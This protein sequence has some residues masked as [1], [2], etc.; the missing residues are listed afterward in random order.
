MLE[1]G[2]SPFRDYLYYLFLFTQ[3]YPS[4]LDQ[5]ATREYLLTSDLK[6]V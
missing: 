3:Y 1:R 5:K 2:S 6:S 4:L